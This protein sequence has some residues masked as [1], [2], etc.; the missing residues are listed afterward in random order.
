MDLP[1]RAFFSE[2]PVLRARG[3]PPSS[4]KRQGAGDRPLR[5]LSRAILWLFF[6]KGP[7]TRSKARRRQAAGAGGRMLGC[8]TL[9]LPA[10]RLPLSR[11]T[12]SRPK[13]GGPEGAW[14]VR[15][16]A[17]I[18]TGCVTGCQRKRGREAPF[19]RRGERRAKIPL[20]DSTGRRTPR[21]HAGGPPRGGPCGRAGGDGRPI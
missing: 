17:E 16:A 5:L 8:Q 3:R 12:S 1:G 9:Q 2:S 6:P 20:S 21:G 10:P 11:Q 18:R 7:D 19:G 14:A 15:L 4:E 13:K